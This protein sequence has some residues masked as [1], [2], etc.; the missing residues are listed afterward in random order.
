MFQ[1]RHEQS[2]KVTQAA[3]RKLYKMT[4]EIGMEMVEET[5]ALHTGNLGVNN[6]QSLDLCMAPGGFTWATRECNPDCIAY[7]IT[8]SPT[9]GGYTNHFPLSHTHL[10]YMDITMIAREFGVE[11]VPITHPDHSLFLDER[12]FLGQHFQIIF[13]GGAVL[14]NHERKDHRRNF[15]KIRLTASQMILAM[16]RILPGGTMVV[17]LRKPD[18]WD[19]FRLLHQ[20]SS[21]SKIELFKPR[22]KHNIKST[23]YLVAKNV[24]PES[25]AARAALVDWKQSW[26]RATFGGDEE[27]GEKETDPDVKDVQNAVEE[28]GPKLVVLAEWVW[29]IQAG[30]LE[31]QMKQPF[32]N[33]TWGHDSKRTPA[34]SSTTTEIATEKTDNKTMRYVP[35]QR[36]K[37]AHS[38]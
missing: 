22:K 1:G 33:K 15:E 28:F 27:I 30:A 31:K 16:Q 34:N 21:F 32:H 23:F 24:E 5:D 37:S 26:A 29:R 4:Q 10:K 36:R 17:L 35:P 11:D 8:L 20:F 12:P 38:A 14:R 13:C 9:A 19:T 3:E 7:G 6:F 2:A 18:S 25:E